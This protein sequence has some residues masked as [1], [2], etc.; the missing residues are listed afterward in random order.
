MVVFADVNKFRILRC[1]YPDYLGGPYMRHKYPCKREAE[2]MG[3]TH[4][5]RRCEDRGRDRSDAV[6]VREWHP[7][8]EAGGGRNR[9]PPGPLGRVA[10]LATPFQTSGFQG[11]EIVVVFIQQVRVNLLQQP[12]G[13]DAPHNFFGR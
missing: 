7:P 11:F 6:T 9:F 12:Q 4:R 1:D 2:G 13:T 10:L 8:P 5:G 3:H